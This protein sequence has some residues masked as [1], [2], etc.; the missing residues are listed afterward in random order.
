MKFKTRLLLTNYSPGPSLSSAPE[1]ASR[2]APP[3]KLSGS[4]APSVAQVII[5]WHG[6]E[7][8]STPED[9][10]MHQSQ[11]R[12]SGNVTI[13]PTGY[14]PGTTTWKRHIGRGYGERVWNFHS[15]QISMCSPTQKLSKSQLFG[16][17]LRLHYMGVVGCHWPLVMKRSLQPASFSRGHGGGA[18]RSKLL[19]TQVVPLAIGPHP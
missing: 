18:E 7:L 14:H 8:L 19:I 4:D 5:H 16:F 17:S 11:A 1:E 3:L 6:D 2:Q 13:L 10:Q 9:M 15:S 12:Y